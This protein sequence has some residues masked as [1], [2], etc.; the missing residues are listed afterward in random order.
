MMKLEDFK[1]SKIESKN[2]I[3]GGADPNETPGGSVTYASVIKVWSSDYDGVNGM[4]YCDM[5]VIYTGP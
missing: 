4:E 3:T 5:R 2:L 1:V